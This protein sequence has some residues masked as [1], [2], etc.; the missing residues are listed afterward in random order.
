MTESLKST[1]HQEKLSAAQSADQ[2]AVYAD[3]LEKILSHPQNQQK[4]GDVLHKIDQTSVMR[5]LRKTWDRLSQAAQ[6][7]IMHFSKGPGVASSTGPIHLLVRLGFINYKGHLDEK[8]KVMEEKV[9]KMGGT[10]RYLLK[11]G[12]KIGKYFFPELRSIEPLV[13]PL[14][15]V[16][17]STDKALSTVRGNLL[18]RRSS[19]ERAK[20]NINLQQGE[21]RS[22]IIDNL[23]LAA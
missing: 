23:D 9:Q 18:S 10:D 1:S 19:K 21:T 11:Y 15:K 4:L 6:W 22:K 20:L 8:G 14:L 13:E 16:S 12:V 2:I 7:A 3:K 5:H 17:K